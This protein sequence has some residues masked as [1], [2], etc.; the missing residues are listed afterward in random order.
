M[1]TRL[2]KH[3]KPLVSK[4]PV[5]A[6]LL[7]VFMV[8]YRRDRRSGT[9]YV[10]VVLTQTLLIVVKVC[11]SVQLPVSHRGLPSPHASDRPLLVAGGRDMSKPNSSAADP[12]SRLNP[13]ARSRVDINHRVSPGVST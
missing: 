9:L 11:K 13:D 1:H 2:V 8:C 12:E 10:S 5:R 7:Y 6:T 3:R 4:C